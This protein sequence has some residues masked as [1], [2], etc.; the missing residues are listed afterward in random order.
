[1]KKKKSDERFSAKG[2]G[3]FTLLNEAH[4]AIAAEMERHYNGHI[5]FG[6][7]SLAESEFH[8]QMDELCM[9]QNN[10]LLD[11]LKLEMKKVVTRA[12]FAMKEPNPKEAPAIAADLNQILAMMFKMMEGDSD[13]TC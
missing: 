3:N 5:S 1:M 4:N 8:R 11:V 6:T 7:G 10:L 9:A 2:N 13:E 12:D